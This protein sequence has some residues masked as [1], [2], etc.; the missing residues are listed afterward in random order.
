MCSRGWIL[1][2]GYFLEPEHIRRYAAAG[3]DVTTSTGFKW[4]KRDMIRERFGEQLLDHF[5]PLRE[6]LDSGMT[7]ACGTDWGPKNIF[8]Q[9]ALACEYGLTPEE[10]LAAWTRHAGH[11]LR[12]EGVGTLT[13]GAHADLIV[14]DRDP[15]STPLGA[16]PATRVLHT[17]LAGA[18]VFDSGAFS[19]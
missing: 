10:S 18:T 4:G 17:L 13:P 8:E 14:V 1:Q 3:F 5:I 15:L 7:V 16:L 11:V 6:L 12:W 2:H 9:I 19:I